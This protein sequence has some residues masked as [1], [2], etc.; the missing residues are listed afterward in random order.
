MIRKVSRRGFLK[1]LA[2]GGLRLALDGL[3]LPAL[4]DSTTTG[5]AAAGSGP[6]DPRVWLAI[7][8]DGTVSIVVAR[9]EMGQG[10][11][12]TLALAIADE[13]E[14]D[15]AR[16]KLV[17]AEGDEAR[18]G[19]QNTDGSRSIRQDL[20]P[21]RRVGA[22]A[23]R[24]LEAAAAQAWG[25]PLAEVAASNHE[26]VHLGT[27]RR[28]GYGE[29]AAAAWR[30][31]VPEDLALKTPERLRYL[32]KEGQP[33]FDL[34]DM[35]TG[36][37]V[38][39]ADVTLPGLRYAMVARPPVYGG[40]VASLDDAAAR[41][42]PGV[43]RVVTLPAGKVPGGFNPL[44]GVAVIATSTWAAKQGAGALAI[45][46]HDGG[47]AHYDS[48]AYKQALLATVAKPGQP[49][50][51]RGQ[52]DRALAK[53]Y[54]RVRATY[55]VPHLAHAPMEPLVATAH[56]TAAGC[57][58]W[59]PTQHPQAARETVASVLGI[60]VERV[61]V[62][63][64]L[65][66]GGFGRKSKPDFIAE[67]ALLSREVGAPVRV[68]WT[69]EDE[70]RHGYYHA[71]SAQ[72]LEAAI[73][74]QGRVDAWL[75]RMAYPTIASTFVPFLNRPL[76]TELGMGVS[77]L[78]YDIPNVRVETGP[79]DAHVRIGWYRAVANI[80]HAFAINSFVAELAASV[81]RDPK[82]QLLAMIGEPRRFEAPKW[83][84]GAEAGLHPVDTGRLRRVI[85]VAAEKAGWGRRLRPGHGLGI[86][87]HRSF[88]SYV[89][90]VVEVAIDADGKLTVPR[91]DTAIDCGFVANPDRVRAQLEGAATM[92]LSNALFGAI[93]FQAGRVEQSNFHDYPVARMDVAPGAVRSWIVASEHPAGGVGEAGVPPFA[94]ALC[95]AIHAAVG[96]RIRHLPIADQLVPAP[97]S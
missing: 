8:P 60:G 33:S 81:G 10:S 90:T 4:A 85:E 52:V 11:R 25:V 48:A 1:G 35:V 64:T 57:E 68:Q 45:R 14:A 72:H 95:N 82:D 41:A 89:A 37:A 5:A 40:S 18:Y 23:R 91:V 75:H 42:V 9:S 20:L 27:G 47:N 3:A 92:G 77:D 21:L 39:G 66:G 30:Q 16:V 53:A 31:P 58:V 73:D 71:V 6:A 38:F 63:V 84:Y 59:A 29:L 97:R 74:R 94:P 69:R 55:Y 34:D 79:A 28:K 80:Q 54:R 93:T 51:K 19:S 2:A 36:R 32:G 78:P 70:L 43:E 12:S 56:V 46:W 62:H 86:A 61:K 15:R 22:A 83:N 65:L 76:D 49:V 67:A 87:A 13:L 44:G 96:K 26:V 7:A 50:A 88:L 17:Q 24:M